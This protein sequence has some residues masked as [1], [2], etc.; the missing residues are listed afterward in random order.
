VVH[1]KN[2]GCYFFGFKLASK[3]IV[4]FAKKLLKESLRNLP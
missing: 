2:G 1:N 4:K 3:A